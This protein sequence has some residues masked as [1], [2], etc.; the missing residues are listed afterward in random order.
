[1][2]EK[3]RGWKKNNL[4]GELKQWSI[5]HLAARRTCKKK[6]PLKSTILSIE[7]WT[8]GEIKGGHISNDQGT[9]QK[10]Q[11]QHITRASKSSTTS[12]KNKRRWVN[13]L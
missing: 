4:E 6:I 10:P 1:L 9:G 2:L 12:F 11:N 7:S 8:G 13:P 5:V 3:G